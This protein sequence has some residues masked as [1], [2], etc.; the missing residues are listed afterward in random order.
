[1]EHFAF[2][3]SSDTS[4]L[5]YIKSR[6]NQKNQAEERKKKAQA[7]AAKGERRA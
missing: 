2:F 3:L 7:K 6:A 1:M 5:I 4:S